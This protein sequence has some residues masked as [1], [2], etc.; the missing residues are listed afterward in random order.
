MNNREQV[1]CNNLWVDITCIDMVRPPKD[2]DVV[3]FYLLADFGGKHIQLFGRKIHV[4]ELEIAFKII[5]DK[6]TALINKD[7]T[8]LGFLAKL[9]IDMFPDMTPKNPGN[10]IIKYINESRVFNE[11]RDNFKKEFVRFKKKIK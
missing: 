3:G 10:I 7:N 11:V 2:S 1:F 4:N 6:G 9:K 8:T 5:S